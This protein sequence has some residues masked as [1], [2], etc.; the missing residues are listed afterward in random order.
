MGVALG[1]DVDALRNSLKPFLALYVGGMGAK[2]KNF[3]Y[4]LACR[5]GYEAEADR[6]QNLYLQGQKEAAALLIPDVLVDAVALCGPKARIAERLDAWRESPF[7]DRNLMTADPEAMR[8]LA[9]LVLGADVGHPERTIS[10]PPSQA[11][12]PVEPSVVAQP[13]PAGVFER[14]A[15]HIAQN[16][17]LVQADKCGLPFRFSGRTRWRVGLIDLKNG[18]G[19]VLDSDACA[20]IVADCTIQMRDED[21]LE[22]AA[23]NLN[24]MV[25]FSTGSF[26][27]RAIQWWPSSWQGVFG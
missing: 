23:G 16:P 11:E 18:T 7:T 12:P 19:A 20:D 25:A 6:V 21:F 27:C 1:D 24:P 5:Y 13:T 8:V 26:V 3:Y 22:L 4:D 14:L 2:G 15:A 17:G 9:E 10:L